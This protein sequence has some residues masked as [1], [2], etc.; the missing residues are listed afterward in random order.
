VSKKPW[1]SQGN[2]RRAF[3]RET[4]EGS[5]SACGRRDTATS[6]IGQV[7]ADGC[8][9][10]AL[11]LA[12]RARSV[13][14]AGR[15]PACRNGFAGAKRGRMSLSGREPTAHGA[16]QAHGAPPAGRLRVYRWPSALCGG[17]VSWLPRFRA[18]LDARAPKQAACTSRKCGSMASSLTAKRP[19]AGRSVPCTTAL[20]AST[21]PARVTSLQVA[22]H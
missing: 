17:C 2:S 9:H 14:R 10:S 11:A 16:P 21:A 3:R 18:T 1:K 4:R 19:C 22:H 12:A 8:C 5:R 7:R 6:R 13:R 15:A 20:S